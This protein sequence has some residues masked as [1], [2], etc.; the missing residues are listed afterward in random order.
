VVIIGIV[1]TFDAKASLGEGRGAAGGAEVN[2][3]GLRR[4][5]WGMNELVLVPL[6]VA[7]AEWCL[8]SGSLCKRISI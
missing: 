4:I 3:V 7:G 6:I 8:L 1:C 2:C 5:E